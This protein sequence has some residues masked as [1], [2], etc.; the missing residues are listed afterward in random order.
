M[1][2]KICR[3]SANNDHLEAIDISKEYQ[4]R[5]FVSVF[6]VGGMEGT[7]TLEC[8]F[9][10][11]VE[12]MSILKAQIPHQKKLTLAHESIGRAFS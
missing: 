2:S 12:T 5:E 11:L 4:A 1:F 8:A 10:K 7:Y 3:N 9:I 6:C